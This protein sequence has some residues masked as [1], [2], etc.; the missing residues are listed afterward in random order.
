MRKVCQRLALRVLPI[1]AERVRA[2]EFSVADKVSGSRGD[3][4][5]PTPSIDFLNLI[6]L[7]SAIARGS[8]VADTAEADY[9]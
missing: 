6:G 8:L 5:V 2:A 3:P 1:A 7:V 4:S 9:D